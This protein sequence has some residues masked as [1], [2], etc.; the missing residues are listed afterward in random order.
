[1]ID[2]KIYVAGGRPPR[3]ADFA[4][5]DPQTDTWE[6]L[7]DLPTARNHLAA[8]AIGG[9]VYVAGGRFGA[10]VGSEMT[11]ALEVY[12]P[13]ERTWSARTPLP[14]VRAGVNGIGAQ[15]CLYVFGGEGNDAHPL[16]IFPQHDRY[17]PWTDTWH[18]LESLPVPVHG[19]TGSAVLDG[20]IHLPGGGTSRGGNSGSTV[21]Q[22]Y[23]VTETCG[24]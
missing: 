3:G 7:P 11:G 16:G 15:G 9:K 10:G 13:V 20:W 17:D 24:V 4:A 5:Y 6:V 8:A 19:V 21:H 22:V 23:R 2:G 18:A 1:M 14:A 12:D